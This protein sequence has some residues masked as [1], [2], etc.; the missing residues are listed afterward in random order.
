M[1][2]YAL[3]CPET[4]QSVLI[5]PGGD[6]DILMEMLGD[7]EPVAIL[8]THSHED[9][10]MA[11]DEMKEKLGVPV[12]A[13][14]GEHAEPI[15]ADIWLEGGQTF[16][17]GKQVLTAVHTP[18]HIGDQICFLPQGSNHYVVGDTIFEGG[19]GRTWSAEGFEETLRTLK[20]IV[21]AWDDD[22]ICY[23]GHG[24]SFRLGDV[25]AQVEGFVERDHGAFF[26]DAEWGM[27]I[28]N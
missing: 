17:F 1:N 19:P 9:H 21:L 2:T 12:V 3:I 18:G 23:P 24:P 16:G 5:D 6:P 22:V 13:H 10:V 4:N 27:G 14:P 8:L 25:R 28:S 15:E 7:S 20:N 26:G 11:L